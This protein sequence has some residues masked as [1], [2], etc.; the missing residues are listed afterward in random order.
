MIVAHFKNVYKHKSA[1]FIKQIKHSI[2]FGVSL[3]MSLMTFQKWRQEKSVTHE[4][5]EKKT[6]SIIPFDT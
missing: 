2:F 6:L 1:K 4:F 5:W 3:T